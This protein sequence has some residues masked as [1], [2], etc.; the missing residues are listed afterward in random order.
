MKPF[1]YAAARSLKEAGALL[2]GKPGKSRI[3]AGGTDLIP[4][5]REGV[6]GPDRLVGIGRIPGLD[7]IGIDGKGLRIGALVPLA[8]IAAHPGIVEGWRGL[9]E[10]AGSAATP[11][12]RNAGTMGGNL[13][14]RP[15]CW[16]FRSEGFRC[17]KKGGDTCFAMDGENKYHA[18]LGGDPCWI[19]HPSDTAPALAAFEASVAVQGAAGERTVSLEKFF[20]LPAADVS[21]ENTLGDDEVLSEVR[22][23]LPPVGTRSAYLKIR[24]KSSFDFALVSCAAVLTFEGK[25]CSRARIVLGGVA[26]VPWRCAAAEAVLAGQPLDDARITRAAAA[27]LDGAAPLAHNRY[28]VGLAKAAIRRVLKGL[29]QG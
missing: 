9:A 22:V 26:P 1:E 7:R 15:R 24:E 25:T 17:L 10:G 6:A 3:L 2:R 5:M 13:C 18:I 29:S 19:V 12:I 11:Q 20:A 21:R 14:Q 23:P 16:Y 28:K 27:A 8:E 4:L